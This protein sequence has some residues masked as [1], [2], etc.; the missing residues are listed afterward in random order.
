[1]TKAQKSECSVVE[2]MDF[3]DAH[4]KDKEDWAPYDNRDEEAEDDDDDHFADAHRSHSQRSKA[5]DID[6]PKSYDGNDI[7]EIDE[8]MYYLGQKKSSHE[9]V[10]S[11]AQTGI[12]SEEV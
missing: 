10:K 8:N 11:L 3:I 9:P 2:A 7:D 5:K 1:M 4:K 12:K 6:K